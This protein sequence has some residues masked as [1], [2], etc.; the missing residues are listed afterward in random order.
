MRDR[1]HTHSLYPSANSFIKVFLPA[2][3]VT[4]E[5]PPN[6]PKIDLLVPD[7][8]AR[9]WPL[10]YG[11]RRHTP[12]QPARR[13]T[14]SL[15]Q[16]CTTNAHPNATGSCPCII[17]KPS[18]SDKILDLKFSYQSVLIS[19][20]RG[21]PGPCPLLW[22]TWSGLSGSKMAR[23]ARPPTP[24]ATFSHQSHLPRGAI[25]SRHVRHASLL[26]PSGPQLG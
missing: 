13:T 16:C 2:H 20:T 10:E 8:I 14:C 24:A 11:R 19:P 21:A 17:Q 15:A 4:S 26:T 5:Y 7:Q 6:A 18:C 25:V 9:F 12:T 23:M 3:R 22:D 1:R